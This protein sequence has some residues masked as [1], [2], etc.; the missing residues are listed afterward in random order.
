MYGV[1]CFT[2]DTLC[3]PM[4]EIWEFYVQRIYSGLKVSGWDI[5]HGP[6]LRNSMVVTKTLLTNVTLL[7]HICW[8]VCLATNCDI[9]LVSLFGVNHSLSGVQDITYSWLPHK[10]RIHMM[11]TSVCAGLDKFHNCRFAA[12]QCT[13]IYE[14]DVCISTRGNRHHHLQRHNLISHLNMHYILHIAWIIAI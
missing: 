3:S 8:R 1:F 7:R 5:L 2:L 14:E 13:R 6:L 4:F 10:P 12:T 9:W 11:Q